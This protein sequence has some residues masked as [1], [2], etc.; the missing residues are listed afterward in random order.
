MIVIVI[1]DS[2]GSV[3]NKQWSH[4][5]DLIDRVIAVWESCG[6]SWTREEY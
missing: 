5:S 1:F 6:F 2:T 4:D 3:V